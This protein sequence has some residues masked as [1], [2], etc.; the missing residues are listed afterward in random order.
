MSV[1]PQPITAESLQVPAD[2][3]TREALRRLAAQSADTASAA[4]PDRETLAARAASL[5]DQLALPTAYLGYAMVVVSNAFWRERFQ[6]VPF[7]RRLLLLPHCLSNAASCPGTYDSVGLQCAACGAC[8]ISHVKSHAEQLGYQVVVAEG[9]SSVI[10]KILE[11]E[12]DALLGVACLDSLEKSFS[13]VVDLHIPHLAVP[14][15]TDGCVNTQ[16]EQEEIAALLTIIGEPVAALPS[17]LP[18]MRESVRL[19]DPAVLPTLLASY[20]T[21]P[22]PGD[23]PQG[24]TATDAIAY[25]WLQRGGKR[26][27]P[28]VTL[29]AYAVAKHGAD[30][31]APGTDVA[32]LL[33]MPIRRLAAAIEALHKASLV[34][35][36]IED[37]DAFRYG[38]ETL[39][40]LLGTAEA[41]NVGDYLVGLGY[42]LIAGEAKTLGAP[43]VG[44]ILG[45]L[46][47]AHL[48]LCRGQGTELRWQHQPLA[49]LPP[50]DVLSMYALKTAPAFEAA[51][52]AG[53]RAADVTLDDRLLKRFSIYIGEG[54]QVRNDLN[55][56]E[57][58]T[59]SA[60]APGRD[61]LAGRPTILRAF[62]LEA[63]AAPAM[64]EVTGQALIDRVQGWYVE[65]G[66]FT[67]AARLVERLRFRAL[68]LVDEVEIPALRELLRFLA[69]IMLP[70]STMGSHG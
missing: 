45:R 13:R 51:L 29:S 12:A 11:G 31:L 64:D 43:C 63:G 61:A 48:D 15:L 46:A 54:F 5:L 33:P 3:T 35:D 70:E 39:H 66:A 1:T 30:A 20:V 47:T 55:D 21:L 6:A 9:T 8:D 53:I 69:R 19:F 57:R 4:P 52:Y 14:L 22:P 27:R 41:I 32:A 65:T 26:L 62:A 49:A 44:D 25:D 58:E 18:L 60:V 2:R 23:A 50:L 37:D 24:I 67:R 68:G 38:R 10:M 7:A 59:G 42:R 16:A 56:W 36:D 34:H 28:F 40:R 17:Y